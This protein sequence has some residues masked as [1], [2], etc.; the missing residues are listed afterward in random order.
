RSINPFHQGGTP[1]VRLHMRSFVKSMS[2]LAT[3]SLLLSFL[4]VPKVAGQKQQRQDQNQLNMAF[5]NAAN[6]FSVPRDLLVAI[7]YA[8]THLDHHKG[9]PSYD[10][11][12]RKHTRR[13]CAAALLRR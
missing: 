4:A 12:R 8:E 9:A 11:H 10:K 5:E 6:E 1:M 2:F 7:A 3:F 13:S